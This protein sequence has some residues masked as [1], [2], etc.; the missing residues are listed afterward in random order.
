MVGKEPSKSRSKST[1]TNGNEIG[2]IPDIGFIHPLQKNAF[3]RLL[4]YVFKIDSDGRWKK[5]AMNLSQETL[6]RATEGDQA[7]FTEIV[8]QHQAMVFSL[9][10]HFLHDWS[11]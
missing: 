4:F 8:R 1:S 10:Y 6:A 11:R 5:G 2:N 3:F 7:A 9:A